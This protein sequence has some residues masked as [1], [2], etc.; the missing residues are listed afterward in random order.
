M[1][2]LFDQSIEKLTAAQIRGFESVEALKKRYKAEKSKDKPKNV[3]V[4]L[5]K[6]KPDEPEDN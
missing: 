4:E 6:M 5:L 1:G 2:E 3:I